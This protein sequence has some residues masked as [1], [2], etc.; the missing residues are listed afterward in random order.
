MPDFFYILG[1][2]AQTTAFENLWFS[3][4]GTEGLGPQYPQG[5]REIRIFPPQHGMA[6]ALKGLLNLVQ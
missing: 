4:H 2:L 6:R 1:L 3:R 5:G